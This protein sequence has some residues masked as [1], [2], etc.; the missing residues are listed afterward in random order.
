[1]YRVRKN[2]IEKT[3]E[4]S[5]AMTMLAARRRGIRKTLSGSSG[6]GAKRPST[7]A[8]SASSA[9][10]IASGPSTP[11]EPQPRVSLRTIP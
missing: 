5:S 8:N 3:P 7:S 2:H 10:A 9:A 6:A 11:A 4:Y 1:M